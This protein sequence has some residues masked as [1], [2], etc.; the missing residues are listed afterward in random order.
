[1]RLYYPR[2]APRVSSAFTFART[3]RVLGLAIPC[4]SV[5]L[6][7]CDFGLEEYPASLTYPVRS[8]PIVVQTPKEFPWDTFAPGQLDAHIAGLKKLEGGQTLDPNDLSS[9]DRNELE[10]VLLKFFGTPSHPTV[11][12]PEDTAADEAV[13]ALRLDEKTLARGSIL[14][15]RHCMHCHGVSGDGRGPTGPWVNPTPRDY[16]QGY[17]KFIST[18]T[19]VN[20]RKPRRDDLHRILDRG[21]EG[22]SMP[23]FTLLDE[24]QKDDLVSYIIH[25]SLRGE[26]EYQTM[27]PLVNKAGIGDY[28]VTE[29][30]EQLGKLYLQAWAESNKESIRPDAY[31]YPDTK[32][33]LQASIRRGYEEFTNTKGAASCI[34]CHTDFGRQVPFRYD[35]WGT[36]VRPANLTAGVYRGG[37]RPIDLYNRIRG[38][39]RPSNMPGADLKVLKDEKIDQYWDVVNFVQALPYPQ[40]LPKD[41]ADAIYGK[42]AVESKDGKK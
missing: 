39:I 7:G 34:G 25:L 14:Y 29:K 40:M 31:P 19:K 13:A 3:V 2:E 41:V 33:A 16:R 36:L 15:R 12:F 5:F 22:T 42:R 1:M 35:F 24:A 9:K 18:E 21:I 10:K 32:E 27:T 26:T 8:D 4:L 30:V 23:S 20:D 28:T 38:G 17:F 11:K 6:S 37:R